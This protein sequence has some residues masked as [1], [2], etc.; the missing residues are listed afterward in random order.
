M[1]PDTLVF[2]NDT[3]FNKQL[4]S[5]CRKGTVAKAVA[6]VVCEVLAA[7]QKKG[8]SAVLAY[9]KQF[10][11]ANLKASDLKV[12]AEALKASE[13]AL[14]PSDRKAIREAIRQVKDFH[15]QT[16]PKNWS[17]T[18]L[19][20]GRVGE[21]F[22]PIERVGLYIPGGNVPLVSTVVMTVVLAKLAGCPEIM[23]CTPPDANGQIAPA[24]LTT[25]SIIGINEV[26][27]IGGVQAVGAMAYGTKTVK[28]V[29]KIY[30]PGNAFVMEAKRQVLGTVGI[31]L[32][33]GPS[34]LMVI[35]DSKAKAEW[36][37]ADLLAQA[38]HGS[39]KELLYCLSTSK[40][41]L[42]R[43]KAAAEKGLK[44]V[45]HADKC[46]KILKERTLYVACSNMDQAAEVANYVAPEHLELQVAES[47]IDALTKKIRTAGAILQGYLTPT[48]LGDFTAGP[49][50]TLPTGRAGRFYSGL[51]LMDF[52]RRTS[53]VR[54][55]SKSIE[56]A[57]PVVRAFA[58][59]EK[60]DAHGRSL[61]IR[62][63]KN[64]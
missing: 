12:S 52:M 11:K 4:E 56:K 35:A 1:S 26:Y 30:G 23:V 31:D 48:V 8:D 7:V 9:T 10:D 20:G 45:S 24:M 28:P 37:A 5:F 62:L 15:K 57:A 40:S 61:E 22:Y 64:S 59:L 2:S 25:L 34:E 36:V 27:K 54:Y 47:T 19:Q 17:A 63:N 18:N 58:R 49:S 38:E 13:Q 55:N 51:Q 14:S 16:M 44:S 43:I 42:N 50:H 41:L 29:D 60:L 3:K 32:L 53:T 21:R 46:A 33:P 39:G 6:S